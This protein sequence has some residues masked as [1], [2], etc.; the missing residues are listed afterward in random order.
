MFVKNVD[1]SPTPTLQFCRSGLGPRL[2]PCISPQPANYH[3]RPW[4]VKA[5][6]C[7]L[8]SRWLHA[9]KF[10]LYSRAKGVQTLKWKAHNSSCS[11]RFRPPKSTFQVRSQFLKN[12]LCG[13][14]LS[15]FYQYFSRALIVPTEK[16][17]IWF[18]IK[19]FSLQIQ[20]SICYW[21]NTGWS[22][23][24]GRG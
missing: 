21:K 2:G 7:S 11:L 17:L 16:H 4:W 15:S 10:Q 3:H 20:C 23:K 1:P 19:T 14:N 12:L 6:D 9:L 22:G 13:N 8:I 5:E 18:R 24:K